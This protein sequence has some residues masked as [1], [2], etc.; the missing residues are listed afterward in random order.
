MQNCD[1]LRAELA[2]TFAK[3]KAGEIKPSEAAELANLAGKMIGSAKVQVEYY[4]LRKE[5]PR[6]NF[7]EATPC[8]DRLGSAE[9]LDAYYAPFLGTDTLLKSNSAQAEK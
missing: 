8:L 2:L 3:L 6:I 7:L 9:S 5:S 1:E 4:V